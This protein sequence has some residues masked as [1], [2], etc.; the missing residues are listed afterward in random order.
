[1][2]RF[3]AFLLALP[4]LPV[5]AAE[6]A[7]SM[8][9]SDMGGQITKLLFGLLLVIGLIFLL[10]W[11]LRWVQQLNRATPRPSSWCRVARSARVTAW[12]WSRSAA[13]RSCSA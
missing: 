7:A 9:G 1:M 4:A 10:A 11:L 5:L 3:A 12:C 13:S 6:P 2:G 8:S